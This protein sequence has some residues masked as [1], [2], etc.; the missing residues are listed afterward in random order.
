MVSQPNP[1]LILIS[2]YGLH[3]ADV[4]LDL[5]SH[6]ALCNNTGLA[7][8]HTSSTHMRDR[9]RGQL[10]IRLSAER[11]V[12]WVARWSSV[13]SQIGHLVPAGHDIAPGPRE[14]G[15]DF[16]MHGMREPSTPL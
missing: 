7:R 14:F 2:D 8:D 9:W 1:S 11:A 13:H 5:T 15:T 12:T 3:F 6:Y 16:K 4:R 10:R